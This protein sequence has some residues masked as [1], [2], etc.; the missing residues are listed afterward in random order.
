VCHIGKSRYFQWSVHDRGYL[1]LDCHDREC[2][3][4]DLFLS[5]S[6]WQLLW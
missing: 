6:Y 4:H 3:Y 5:V 1:D 2:L